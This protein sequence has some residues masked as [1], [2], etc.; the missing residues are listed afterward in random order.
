[1]N[2][3]AGF[4]F[5]LLNLFLSLLYV[6][7]WIIIIRAVV[8][9]VGPDPYNPI[10]Q[11]LRVVTEPVLRPLRR[12]VPPERLGGLDLS[13]LIAILL[14]HLFRYTVIYGISQRPISF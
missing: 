10:V 3:L 1:M 5:A 7:S 4:G 2:F 6:Y 14:I 12:I 8:S 9:W 11:I 13:P